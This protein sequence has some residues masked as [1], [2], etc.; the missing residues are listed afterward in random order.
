MSQRQPTGNTGETIRVLLVDDHPIVRQGVKMMITQEPGMVVCG[1]AESAD[2]ALAAMVESAP[3]VAIVDLTLKDSS[4]L[5]LIKDAKIRCPKVAVLVLSMRDEA[6]Y[7][8]RVLRAGARGYI[9]KEE[10]SD[11]IIEGIRA[12]VGGRIYLSDKLAAKMIGT[13]VVGMPETGAPL[14]ETL[15]DRELEVFELIGSGL[16]TRDIAGK[17]HR[18]GKTIE[19]HREHIKSKLGLDNANELVTRAVQWVESVKKT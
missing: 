1:E 4:G 9:T 16:T 3:E 2:E 7:A 15:S 17:L 6:F 10:G 12:V 18:S 11:R 5:E 19:S 13:Y 8:H 14:E